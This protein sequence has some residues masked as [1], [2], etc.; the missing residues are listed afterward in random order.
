MNI[1]ESD[2]YISYQ[3]YQKARQYERS[4]EKLRKQESETKAIAWHVP[5][6]I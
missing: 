3:E 2:H 6:L 5:M 4:A 1:G